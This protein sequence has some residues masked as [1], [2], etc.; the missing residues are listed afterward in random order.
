MEPNR[1]AR[2]EP[3][4]ENLFAKS[5]FISLA[6]PGAGVWDG[7]LLA[8]PFVMPLILCCGVN[9]CLQPHSTEMHSSSSAENRALQIL[10]ALMFLLVELVESGGS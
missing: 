8:N 1:K 5:S 9:Q 7:V 2:R 4:R 3:L 10:R 6:I